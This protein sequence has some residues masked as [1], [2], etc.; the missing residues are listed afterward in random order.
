MK[1]ELEKINESERITQLGK[2]EY[3]LEKGY[4]E[5]HPNALS[6]NDEKGKGEL[7][8]SIGSS[9]DISKRVESLGKNKFTEEKRYPNFEI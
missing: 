2:N 5:S 7:N 3:T 1:T 8:G 6:N 9:I 4:S